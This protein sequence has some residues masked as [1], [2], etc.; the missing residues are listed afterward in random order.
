NGVR[1]VSQ[2]SGLTPG[3]QFEKN[4][5]DKFYIMIGGNYTYSRPKSDIS[6][7]SNQP[8]YSYSLEGNMTIK[9]P[10]KFSVTAEGNYTN[11]GNRTPGYNLN[12]FIL[13][14]SV[15]KTFFKTENLIVSFIANDI[16]NQNISNKRFIS[17]NQIVDTKTQIIKRYFLLK[18]VFKFNS[19]KTK[20]GDGD[21]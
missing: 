1:N 19:Q 11:N 8:Y 18:V 21:E 6:V 2:N 3:L 20:E 14:G 15:N 16:F 9:L 10:K 12:Y 17:S 13:N 7:Q 4:I 5:P